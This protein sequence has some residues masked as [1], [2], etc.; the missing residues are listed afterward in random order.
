M[1]PWS[2]MEMEYHA[3]LKYLIV[4]HIYEADIVLQATRLSLFN[5]HPPKIMPCC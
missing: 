2:L 3:S 4:P 5:V 1:A